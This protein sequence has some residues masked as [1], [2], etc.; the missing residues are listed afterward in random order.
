[1]ALLGGASSPALSLLEGASPTLV[2]AGAAALVLCAILIMAAA[3]HLLRG[4]P[5]GR[6]FTYGN[7]SD[8]EESEYDEDEYLAEAGGMGP[9]GMGP[10]QKVLVDI[11][12]RV[13]GAVTCRTRGCRTMRQLRRHV[14]H[15]AKQLSVSVHD[16]ALTLEYLDE[17]AGVAILVSD[18]SQLP[19]VLSMPTLKATFASRDARITLRGVSRGVAS[20]ARALG[21]GVGTRAHGGRRAAYERAAMEEEE[22]SGGSCA[23]Q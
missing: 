10:G 15:A 5:C 13:V 12:G 1:M 16:S 9:G 2:L 6:A 21:R 17:A 23:V 18:Q 7:Y 20:G 4:G 19:L 14:C 8:E 22:R 11:G 3:C